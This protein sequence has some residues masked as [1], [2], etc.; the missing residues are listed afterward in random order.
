[1]TVVTSIAA[2]NVGRVLADRDHAIMTRA[3][4]AKYLCMVDRVYGRKHIGV[5]AVFAHIACLDM[6]R[7]LAGGVGAVMAGSTVAGDTSV[8]KI[9]WYPANRRVAVF[10]VVASG[11]VSWVFTDRRNTIVTRAASTQHLRV[12]DSE[13]GRPYIRIVAVFADVACLDMCGMLAGG[14]GA[15]MTAGAITGNAHVIKIRRQPANRR[16]AVITIIATCNMG[17]MFAGR[18]NSVMAGTAHAQHLCVV[19]CGHRLKRY[20]AVAVF[21]DIG[22]LYVCRA[23]ARS[24]STIVTTNAVSNDAGVIENGRYP[25]SCVVTVVTLIS[26]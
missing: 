14:V 12:I 19:N 24:I 5:V 2:G 10:A 15:V 20:C 8:I 18:G 16:V 25:A 9:R 22:R 26:G 3:A 6:R 4:G 1:M 17:Y 23:P 21:A 13:R 11:D 7:I